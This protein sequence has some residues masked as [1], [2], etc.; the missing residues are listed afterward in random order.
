MMIQ[1]RV[2][3]KT[4]VIDQKIY[5]F[6]GSA[7]NITSSTLIPVHEVECYNI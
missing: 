4:I 5:I 7:G 3:P 2:K 1:G 6:G